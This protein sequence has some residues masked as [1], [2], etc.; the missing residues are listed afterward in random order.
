MEYIVIALVAFFVS[1]MTLFS[2][3]G[4]GTLLLPAFALFFPVEVAVGAT[5]LVHGAN[6]AFK[7]ALLGKD[8]DRDLVI[9]FGVPALLAAVPGAALLGL[10][11]SMDPLF[12]YSV[13]ARVAEVTPVKLTIAVL[14]LLFGVLELLPGSGGWRVGRSHMVWGGMLSGFFGGLSGHQGALRAAFLAK[15]A[16]SAPVFVGTTAVI[17]LLVDV[18]RISTYS[19][20][21]MTAGNGPAMSSLDWGLLA[22]AVAA[23]F[24]GVMTGRRYLHKVTMRRIQILT[25]LLLLAIAV[26]M[27]SGVL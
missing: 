25:G 1:G 8:A 20:I 21:A 9:R 2:G 10:L 23:A 22:T 27:G 26:A 24:A 13:G 17:A 14:M 6:S 11:V 5:A 12:T 7:A 16:A 3:F 15:V 18:M 19:V 4:L